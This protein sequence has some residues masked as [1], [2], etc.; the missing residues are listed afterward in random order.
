VQW[1]FTDPGFGWAKIT[2]YT[3]AQHVT[4]TVIS[5]LPDGA[6]GAKATTRWAFSAWSSADGYPSVVTFFRGRCVYG[7]GQS[8]AFSVSDDF[9]NFSYTVDGIVT[10]DSGFQRDLSSGRVNTIRWL[11]A[12]DAL[13][14]GTEGDEWAVSEG[15]TT[16]AFG[17]AN[18]KASPRTYHG[19]APVQP[20]QVVNETVFVQQSGRKVRALSLDVWTG[21]GTAPDLTAFAPHITVPR[22]TQLAY[23]QEPWSIVWGVRAD[24]VLVGATFSREQD[25]LAMHRHTFQGGVVECIET[26]PAP[27]QSRD[28]LW[29]IVRF[30]I[31]GVTRRY[32]GYMGVE[33][34]ETGAVDQADWCYSDM[35]STY[36]G[37]RTTTITGLGYLEGQQVWVL[38]D[39]ANHP[40]RTVVGGSITL[41]RAASKVQVGLPCEANLITTAMEPGSPTGSSFGDTKRAHKVVV[42]VLRSLGGSL[43][44]AGGALQEITQRPAQT[45]MGSGPPPFSGDVPM[46]YEGGYATQLKVQVRKDS[47]RPLTIVAIAPKLSLAER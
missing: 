30:T 25:V 45:P 36:E 28:D 9:E 14:V 16:E 29:V 24:G 18:A 19:S 15:T 35:L 32:V 43:G 4:A 17:P 20:V 21:K 39:G 7:W 46:D 2:A 13:F 5:T 38:A 8:L 33:D 41:Q 3:D 22:I 40:T 47:P 11:A 12:G 42:R 10:A 23:Q 27:D 1:Q 6:V 26:M 31:N 37:P 34:D 44:P